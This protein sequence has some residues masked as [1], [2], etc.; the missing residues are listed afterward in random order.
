MYVQFYMLGVK[1]SVGHF[2]AF[3]DDACGSCDLTDP[4]PPPFPD[5]MAF[6]AE[7]LKN[8]PELLV[9]NRTSLGT[10]CPESVNWTEFNR[11]LE[12]GSPV[13][14]NPVCSHST[15]P[16]PTAVNPSNPSDV[17]STSFGFP[18]LTKP[19]G[20]IV[21]TTQGSAV[22]PAINSGVKD[23]GDTPNIGLP[24]GIAIG[25]AVLLLIVIIVAVC[26]RRLVVFLKNPRQIK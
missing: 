6:F 8:L 9:D 20:S 16:Y 5:F 14:L 15:T 4:C 21:S 18:I 17:S 7:T 13:P 11:N 26:V 19:P 22:P 24:V 23:P 1:S 3:K 10:D 2:I 12:T 25:A